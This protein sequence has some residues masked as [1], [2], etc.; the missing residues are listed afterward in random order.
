MRV[1][2]VFFDSLYTLR[3]GSLLPAAMTSHLPDRIDQLVANYNVGTVK[4]SDPVLQKHPCL[5]IYAA[6]RQTEVGL[7]Q[8]AHSVFFVFPVHPPFI[9]TETT[10]ESLVDS[11]KETII[12][13]RWLET[14]KS[15]AH[16]I[17]FQHSEGPQK[18]MHSN[19][20]HEYFAQPSNCKVFA[21]L[22]PTTCLQLIGIRLIFRCCFSSWSIEHRPFVP[23]TGSVTGPDRVYGANGSRKPR[24]GK[25]KGTGGGGREGRCGM[26]YSSTIMA[27]TN[28]CFNR[29]AT[30]TCVTVSTQGSCRFNTLIRPIT[31]VAHHSRFA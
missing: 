5:P 17:H 24:I 14:R 3:R 8:M 2:M 11:L 30:S 27:S 23:V 7:P 13:L 9:W 20:I 22:L 6:I 28:P 16:G 26:I 19:P 25:S 15:Q 18:C 12:S 10:L 21:A 1:R 29:G 4:V 31:G